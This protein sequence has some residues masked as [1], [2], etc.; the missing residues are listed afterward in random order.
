MKSYYSNKQFI[1]KVNLKGE[2]LGFIEKW[3]AHKEGIMH[4]GFAVVII[5]KNFYLLQH[6]KHPCFDGVMDLSSASHQLLK[7]NKFE[8]LEE[9]V[10]FSLKREWNISEDDLVGKIKNVGFVYYKSKD[11]KS[12]YTEHEHCD[13]LMI[14]IKKLPVPNLDFAYGFSLATKAEITNKTG[15]IYENLSPWA[16]GIIDKKMI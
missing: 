2:Y 6:R 11:P 14:K 3:K 16:K 12:R 8:N 7:N 4:R 15:R 13:I 5:Y 1:E 10:I 9:A